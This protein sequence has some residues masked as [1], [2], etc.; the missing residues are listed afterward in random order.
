MAKKFGEY[1]FLIFLLEKIERGNA[2]SFIFDE[3]FLNMVSTQYKKLTKK[4]LE[5]IVLKSETHHWIEQEGIGCNCPHSLTERGKGVAISK[6]IEYN[7]NF[8]KKT[9]RFIGN[10][11]NIFY[12]IGFCVALV[13]AYVKIKG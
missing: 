13:V 11:K 2:N 1:H 7:E 5:T 10:Y 12:F 6:R 3:S 9:N 4:E 8:G